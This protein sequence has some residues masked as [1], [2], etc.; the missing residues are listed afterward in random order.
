MA[1]PPGATERGTSKAERGISLHDA[2]LSSLPVPGTTVKAALRYGKV[3]KWAQAM[4]IEAV[5]PSGARKDYFLKVQSM[6][7]IA[8]CMIE[9]EFESLKA[10]YA[11]SPKFVPEPFAMG[12]YQQDGHDTFF[13]LEEFRPVGEQPPEPVAFT[14]RVAELHKKSV[15]PTG[16]FG[17]HTTVVHGKAPQLTDQWDESWC[18]VYRK[19]L[20]HVVQH[21][22]EKLGPWPEFKVVATIVLDQV[23][24]RLLEPLQSQGRSIKPCL[25]HGNLWDGNTATDMRTG[26]PFIFD[27][28][29]MYAHNEFETGNWR[30]ARHRLSNNSYVRGYKRHFPASEPGDE[31]EPRRILYSLRFNL[32]AAI[33]FPGSVHRQAVFDD[34]KLLCEKYFPELLGKRMTELR[35]AELSLSDGRLASPGA[36]SPGARR[37]ASP[38]R[39]IL[40][41][42]DEESDEDD[43]ETE[44]EP[45]EELPE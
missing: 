4:K 34:M 20:G 2:I 32:G 11:V 44:E 15:S 26:E 43:T 40:E 38:R 9:G 45:E 33:N 28:G 19:L 27:P 12:H 22:Q 6:P 8:R 23:T 30:A 17:F 7:E 10:L 24:P 21:D 29:S 36:Q 5:L 14:A 31:W 16:K 42:Y 39:G 41:T 37:G 3:A 18:V 13:L 35:M 25:V 1:A